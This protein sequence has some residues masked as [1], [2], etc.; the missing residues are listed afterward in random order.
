[1]IYYSY[2]VLYLQYTQ[3][4]KY[5]LDVIIKDIKKNPQETVLKLVIGVIGAILCI[6]FIDNRLVYKLFSFYNW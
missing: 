1:M 4:I 5:L 3:E 6:F 2:P